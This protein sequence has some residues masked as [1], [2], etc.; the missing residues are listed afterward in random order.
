MEARPSEPADPVV[1][2]AAVYRAVIIVAATR[3][4][5]DALDEGERSA[6]PLVGVLTP[7]QAPAASQPVPTRRA[8]LAGRPVHFCDLFCSPAQHERGVRLEKPLFL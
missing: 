6:R 2:R 3:L 8:H 5:R 7:S 4:L 1:P